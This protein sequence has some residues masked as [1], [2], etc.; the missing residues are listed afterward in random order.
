MPY[1][2]NPII[3]GEV[4]QIPL[5]HIPLLERC[6]SEAKLG[7]NDQRYDEVPKDF[8]SDHFGKPIVLWGD[9]DKWCLA[10]E[11]PFCWDLQMDVLSL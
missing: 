5:H 9:F 10:R 7:V 6:S 11:C 1:Y 2:E 4:M 3:L 8:M